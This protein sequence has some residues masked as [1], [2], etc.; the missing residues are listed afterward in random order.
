MFDTQSQLPPLPPITK[1]EEIDP[2]HYQLVNAETITESAIHNIRVHIE[3][4]KS[5][6][7]KRRTQIENEY[8]KQVAALQKEKQKQLQEIDV[9]RALAVSGY[10]TQLL[11][12]SHHPIAQ[13]SIYERCKH[14]LLQ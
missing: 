11:S 7:D 13:P 9:E 4:I 12:V 8:Q 14:Y 1:L 10:T 2:P 5:K 6:F 3:E